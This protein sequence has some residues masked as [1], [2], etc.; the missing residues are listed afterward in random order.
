MQMTVTGSMEHVAVVGA[1]GRGYAHACTKNVPCDKQVTR[2]T[3]P[4]TSMLTPEPCPPTTKYCTRPSDALPPSLSADTE[5]ES[6]MPQLPP[7]FVRGGTE[8][9]TSTHAPCDHRGE[10]EKGVPTAAE[11]RR[12]ITLPSPSPANEDAVTTINAPPAPQVVS[13]SKKLRGEG[14]MG[15]RS[16]KM[17][18]EGVM[19][20][21]S[22]S[23]ANVHV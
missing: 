14:G 18:E 13:A 8:T 9:L 3:L 16:A 12:Q 15:L 6:P 23:R 22:A 4:L 21:A 11:A 19:V 2:P 20:V 5:T 10:G 17:A 7:P 1:C